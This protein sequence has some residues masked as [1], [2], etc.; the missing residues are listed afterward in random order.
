[1][2]MSETST[3]VCEPLIISLPPLVLAASFGNQTVVLPSL[4]P[5]GSTTPLLNASFTAAVSAGTDL[6]LLL[7][8]SSLASNFTIEPVNQPPPPCQY[9]SSVAFASHSNIILQKASTWLSPTFDT[10][11][12]SAVLYDAS[13]PFAA[14]L[15]SSTLAA[16][17]AVLTFTFKPCL[18]APVYNQPFCV[19]PYVMQPAVH[20]T[21][22]QRDARFA[23]AFSQH[24]GQSQMT[25]S[26]P[27]ICAS[28]SLPLPRLHWLA[29]GPDMLR[30]QTITA[31]V[32]A[33]T[34]F[35]TAIQYRYAAAVI[36]AAASE[37]VSFRVRLEC[38]VWRVLL[39]QRD[40]ASVHASTTTESLCPIT[41]PSMLPGLQLI[42]TAANCRVLIP[43]NASSG[44][45]GFNLSL[46]FM[47]SPSAARFSFHLYSGTAV[48]D[49]ATQF[50][51]TGE[52]VDVLA[53]ATFT[54]RDVG[55]VFPLC[56][57][58]W[59][60]AASP[61]VDASAFN[62]SVTRMHCVL[63]FVRPCAVCGRIS[64]AYTATTML[65]RVSPEL[66][67]ALNLETVRSLPLP[68]PGFSVSPRALLHP[69]RASLLLPELKR[70]QAFNMSEGHV[71]QTG[72][73]HTVVKGDSL[74]TVTAVLQSNLSQLEAANPGLPM[75]A[76]EAGTGGGDYELIEGAMLCVQPLSSS[77]EAT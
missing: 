6:K 50:S 12:S 29:V 1:M 41:P 57:V 59:T 62:A 27:L 71:L 76:S 20:P 68:P 9:S 28:Y 17:L 74:A 40:S 18:F 66:L 65:P 21:I 19:V 31:V 14:L 7:L 46:S 38:F 52:R 72:I 32:F 26:T 58:I 61:S 54:F 3:V 53:E 44:T 64:I 24:S 5:T 10:P 55:A 60:F 75:N 4:V 70:T 11:L 35:P 77:N 8:V 51:A 73:V 39:S 22:V 15:L 23:Y 16:R 45:S 48:N 33:P 43:F 36:S 37:V 63:V 2:N 47:V 25:V 69:Q 34:Q 49:V 13:S 67:M 42:S 30:A 56:A